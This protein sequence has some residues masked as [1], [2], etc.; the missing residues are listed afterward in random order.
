MKRQSQ[1]YLDTSRPLQSIFLSLIESVL[2]SKPPK[3]GIFSPLL[4]RVQHGCILPAFANHSAII[5]Q[6]LNASS[7]R[8]PGRGSMAGL[9]SL[10]SPLPNPSTFT[11]SEQSKKPT[12][13]AHS[14]SQRLCPS[15]GN[16][17]VSP[18]SSAQPGSPSTP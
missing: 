2:A 6:I 17:V 3:L 10:S 18:Q 13:N 14:Q 1:V 12:K 11:S 8:K 9:N 15:S 16:T 7:F 4:T 5:C